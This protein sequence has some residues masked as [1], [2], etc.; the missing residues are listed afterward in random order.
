[1]PCAI[2]GSTSSSVF[3]LSVQLS[4][5]RSGRAPARARGLSED[6]TRQ[7]EQRGVESGFADGLSGRERW[8]DGLIH[9]GVNQ[10]NVKR[11]Q[12]HENGREVMLNGGQHGLERFVAPFWRGNALSPSFRPVVCGDSDDD[13]RAS[14][15]SPLSVFEE[16]EPSAGW[17]THGESLDSRDSNVHGVECRPL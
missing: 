16:L 5:I 8:G 4:G 6:A 14:D 10:I 1:M 11:I 7:V 13:R 2:S 3:G 15:G 12:S 17:V 9:H